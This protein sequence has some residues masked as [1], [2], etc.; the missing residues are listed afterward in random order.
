MVAEILTFIFRSVGCERNESM[1]SSNILEEMMKENVVTDRTDEVDMKLR[2]L[3]ARP[4]TC[5]SSM[6]MDIRKKISDW[7]E[8]AEKEVERDLSLDI[9]QLEKTKISK[10][11]NWLN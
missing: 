1:K 3:G 6:T 11:L 7:Y 10:E 8:E 4:K 9:S 5:N 2:E